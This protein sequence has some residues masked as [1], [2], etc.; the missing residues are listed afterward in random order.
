M[1]IP[2]IFSLKALFCFTLALLVSVGLGSADT[3]T[4]CV[5]GCN[6]TSIQAAV[7]AANPG[8]T[9][10]VSAGTYN[11]NIQI[12]KSIN[13]VG[14]GADVTT[15]NG[16]EIN[17][18][19]ILVTANRVNV[20]GFTVKGATS[21]SGYIHAGIKLSGSSNCKIEK[22]IATQNDDAGFF[23]AQES[24]KNSL[25]NITASENNFGFLIT[26][27]SDFN[28]LE[29]NVV[30]SNQHGIMVSSK[31]NNIVNNRV[32]GNLVGINIHTG[33]KN[34]V[35]NNNVNNNGW[36]GIFL[37]AGINNTIINNEVS[38]NGGG[39]TLLMHRD[40][41]G[42]SVY[43]IIKNNT[44]ISNRMGISIQASYHN[45]VY[46]NNFINNSNQSRGTHNNTWDNGYPSG[47]NYWSDFDEPREGCKDVNKD[48]I[49][50]SPY[51]IGRGNSQD[52]YPVTSMNGWSNINTRPTVETLTPDSEEPQQ[53]GTFI[54][55]SCLGNDTEG[56]LLRY[57]FRMRGPSTNNTWVTTRGFKKGRKW[58][59]VTTTEDIGETDIKCVVKDYPAHNKASKIYHNY[60]ITS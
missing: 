42:P 1:L 44:V 26:T 19:V 57:M 11:E 15:I 58:K 5:S 55:W 40:T 18:D 17:T 23:I 16:T 10:N 6:Y 51:N 4:V 20:S 2:K 36:Q 45:I 32:F 43:N 46:H 38:F 50:D 7:D 29:N 33:H 31:N 27:Q 37:M 56:D 34:I 22:V 8:D 14:A 21:P 53:P 3:V 24:E 60:E 30:N 12:N 41:W 47:G 25:S 59:W 49:C 28:I 9:V 39:I 35:D 52:R 54:K 48:K 13:L